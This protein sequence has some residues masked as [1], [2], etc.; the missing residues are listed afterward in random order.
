MHLGGLLMLAVPVYCREQRHLVLGRRRAI[1]PGGL[2]DVVR[3][4]SCRRLQYLRARDTPPC[5]AS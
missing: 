4:A 5:P 3:V 2:D 1:G